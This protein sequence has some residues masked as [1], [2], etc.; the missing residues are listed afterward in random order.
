MNIKE[1]SFAKYGKSFQQ[2]L[3]HLMLI[4]RPF[5]DQ[6]EEVL[7]LNFFELRYLQIFTK[8]ILDYRNKYGVH[9]SYEIV[10]GLINTELENETDND[11]KLVH[12]FYED[13]VQ[14]GEPKDDEYIKDA[15]LE[16]C[17]KR[18]LAT[19]M[20]KCIDHIELLRFDEV[21]K[22]IDEA[23]RL[24]SDS[25][26]GHD[27]VKDFEARYE[28]M[29]RS[30]VTTGWESIDAITE[31]GMGKSELGVVIAASGNGKSMCLVHFG[32]QAIKNGL[33]VV[34]YTLEL[35]DSV[36]AKRFDSVI[37]GFELNELFV[38]KDKVKE[39]LLSNN[40]NYGKLVVKEYAT[41]QAS[42]MTIRKH[43]ERLALNRGF[44]PDL[45]IV[46]YG[47]LLRP[48][49]TKSEKRFELSDIYENLRA[50]AKDYSCPVWTASQSNRQG[51]GAEV[52]TKEHIAEAFNKI[53]VADF[54]CSISRTQED[55]LH[56]SGKFYVAKNRNGVD[57]IV[58]PLV[59]DTAKVFID[60]LNPT[61]ETLE[62]LTKHAVAKQNQ[63]LK[64]KMKKVFHDTNNIEV[65]K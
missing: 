24:G 59:M 45:I 44:R 17:R 3:A 27:Y 64:N 55:K 9:P 22:E 8:L 18:K 2:Q 12:K 7:E 46:D 54:V 4:D 43:L 49:T 56:N 41:G 52:I 1:K 40:K 28:E 30:P 32:A 14:A 34:Y 29:F 47:D 38:Y 61:Q 35:M 53:F 37:T 62:D 5:C 15:S 6:M 26:L 25:D 57:G 63:V 31:G 48:I 20:L 42:V 50:L 21:K 65:N 60:V 58:Y 16:F 11:V 51:A 13:I 23:M 36:V 10:E 39:E 33:N 19:A